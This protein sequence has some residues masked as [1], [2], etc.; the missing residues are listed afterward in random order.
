MQSL[1]SELTLTE[2]SLERNRLK[3]RGIS[4]DASAL[5]KAMLRIREEIYASVWKGE[6][7]GNVL[8]DIVIATKGTVNTDAVDRFRA[9]MDEFAKHK[10]EF[11]AGYHCSYRAVG[12]LV[13]VGIVSGDMPIFDRN[14]QEIWLPIR[15][16]A[17][18]DSSWQ[19]GFQ[20]IRH[21]VWRIPVDKNETMRGEKRCWGLERL[22]EANSGD[23]H[24][25]DEAVWKFLTKGGNH[26][27]GPIVTFVHLASALGRPLAS[28]DFL[29]DKVA[30]FANELRLAL[31]ELIGTRRT[32][33]LTE[34][35]LASL[36][37]QSLLGESLEHVSDALK[38]VTEKIEATKTFLKYFVEPHVLVKK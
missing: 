11:V 34:K 10:G 15:P 22:W 8:S 25:G 9:L 20:N 17:Y 32:L 18:L 7:T 5:E 31:P 36:E 21:G 3:R 2:T 1:F 4:Q 30:P 19:W 14:R 35:K 28:V 13:L 38:D 27:Y 16:A 37:K 6:S 23:I 24:I 33:T 12:L 26:K 29:R